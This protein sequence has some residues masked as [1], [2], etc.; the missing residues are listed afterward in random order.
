[1]RTFTKK[2]EKTL[3]ETHLQNCVNELVVSE[4]IFHEIH[5]RFQIA[6]QIKLI[7]YSLRPIKIKQNLL[8]KYL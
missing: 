2:L 7:Q 5:Q 6:L 1:M 4:S 8:I 3:N